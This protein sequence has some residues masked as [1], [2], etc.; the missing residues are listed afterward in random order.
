VRTEDTKRLGYS[1]LRRNKKAQT[2]PVSVSLSRD[3]GRVS[4]LL[5]NVDMDLGEKVERVTEKREERKYG[6]RKGGPM[7]P[8]KP[9]K[10]PAKPT[11][12]ATKPNVPLGIGIGR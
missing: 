2:S 1:Q 12:K 5:E 4:G 6:L 11:P 10:S 9:M 7:K 3:R 8:M